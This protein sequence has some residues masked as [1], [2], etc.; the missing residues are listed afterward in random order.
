MNTILGEL[1]INSK[2]SESLLRA[3][4]LLQ[5]PI[6]ITICC[7]FILSELQP[8]NCL[9]DWLLTKQLMLSETEGHIFSYCLKNFRDIPVA[10]YQQLN[11]DQLDEILRQNDLNISSEAEA[12][13]TLL[14]WISHNPEN[15]MT[16][17]SQLATRIDFS[18]VKQSVS[19][20]VSFVP[21]ST[22]KQSIHLSYKHFSL[23][24][25]FLR[26]YQ[27]AQDFLYDMMKFYFS[28][29]NDADRLISNPRIS[30]FILISLSAAGLEYLEK[31]QKWIPFAK[32]NAA[33]MS[34]KNI[35][36]AY[37]ANYILYIVIETGYF[38]TV[39]NY[40]FKNNLIMGEYDTM[41]YRSAAIAFDYPMLYVVGRDKTFQGYIKA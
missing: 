18:L 2:N 39:E 40:D 28:T 22:I 29:T 5:F 9:V 17:T 15:R 4:H 12:F 35:L 27:E 13:S 20:S 32:I 3:A 33:V 34:N 26:Q 14:S 36:A 10:A 21:A 37:I 25:D 1:E 41:P 30:T 19:V 24:I 8:N 38:I 11:H 16:H 7:E 31:N 6:A 23:S